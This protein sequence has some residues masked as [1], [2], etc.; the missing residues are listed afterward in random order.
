MTVVSLAVGPLQENVYLVFNDAKEALL[1]DPGAQAEDIIALIE[2][3]KV[4]PQAILLTHAHWDHIGAVDELRQKYNIPV[5]VHPKEADFLT[6][7][8]RNLSARS[9]Q[10]LTATPADF[11][12]EQWGPTR[13]G[14]FACSIYEV[15]GHS[16]GSTVFVFPQKGVAIVGDTLF[17]NGTGRVDLPGSSTF[18][19]L[20]AGI[21]E[22]LLSLPDDTIILPGHGPATTIKAE[23]AH[24]PYLNGLTR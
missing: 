18:Q 22:H 8:Q 17:A 23:K 9:G 11:Y 1:F 19:Q 15:P 3:H 2:Q 13:F 7:P 5:Y 20:L 6:N 10:S 21:T 12:Y 4:T 24:N 14:S 16:P